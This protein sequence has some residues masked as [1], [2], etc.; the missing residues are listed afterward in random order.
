MAQHQPPQQGSSAGFEAEPGCGPTGDVP[1][2]IHH[3]LAHDID[4]APSRP[5][6]T[7][8]P[9]I[10]Q[11]GGHILILEVQPVGWVVAELQFH[12]NQ[13]QYLESHRAI[14]HWPREAA[15]ALLARAIHADDALVT[16]LA[17]KLS[18]WTTTASTRVQ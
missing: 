11:H 3:T 8:Q 17:A 10:W 4:S 18:Q 15:G 6:A 16:A 13:C 5:Y 1:L 2:H 12:A 9:F 7:G 14:Y